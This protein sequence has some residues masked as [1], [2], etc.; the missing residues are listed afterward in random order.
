MFA[1]ASVHVKQWLRNL[2]KE[3]HHPE[4][5]QTRIDVDNISTT[6]L[7]KNPIAHWRSKHKIRSTLHPTASERK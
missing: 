1:V 6:A 4:N 5:K 7:A 3:M 2:M